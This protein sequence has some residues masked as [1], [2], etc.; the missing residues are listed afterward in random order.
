MYETTE[1]PIAPIFCTI[2][3]AAATLARGTRFI[4]QAIATG[5][6][7]AVKSDKRTLVVMASLRRY[8]AERPRANIKPL[9]RKPRHQAE[10]GPPK[11]QAPASSGGHQPMR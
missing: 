2:P 11:A 5:Q 7:E 6:I 4:Y 1:T 9:Y 8:A 3:Q 10:T